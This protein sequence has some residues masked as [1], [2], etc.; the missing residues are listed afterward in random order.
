MC[1]Y[2]YLSLVRLALQRGVRVVLAH[3]T[4][5]ELVLDYTAS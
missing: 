3:E 1:I 2:I 4:E 5:P